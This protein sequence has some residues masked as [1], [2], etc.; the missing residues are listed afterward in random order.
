MTAAFFAHWIYIGPTF[1]KHIHDVGLHVGV[2]FEDSRGTCSPIFEKRPC[3]APLSRFLEGAAGAP[4][5][6]L[7]ELMNSSVIAALCS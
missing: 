5:K 3:I 4:Y 1:S 2:D 6:F 7:N